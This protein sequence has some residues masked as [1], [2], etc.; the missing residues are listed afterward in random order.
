M[1][2]TKTPPKNPGGFIVLQMHQ[3]KPENKIL[4]RHFQECRHDPDLDRYVCL[5][6]AGLD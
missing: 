3:A 2:Q 4:C 1:T 6:T 5:S